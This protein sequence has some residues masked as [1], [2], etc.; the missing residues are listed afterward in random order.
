MAGGASAAVGLI[1]LLGWILGV[2]PLKSTFIG[3]LPM[4]ANTASCFLLTGVGVA[5]LSRPS[6]RA[7]GRWVAFALIGAAASIALV[8]VS[9]YVSGA[10]LGIDQVLF[11][12]APGQ[13][14]TVGP[15]RMS[16]LTS[17]CFTL[18]AFGA[19]ATVRARPAVLPLCGAALALSALNVFTFVFDASVPSFLAA[20]SQMAVNTAI[21]MGVLAV[22][23]IGLLGPASPFALLDR[24]SPTASLLRR[25][26]VAL[27]VVPLSLAWLTQA[28]QRL[29]LYDAGYGTA[30]RLVAVLTLGTI[31]VIRWARWTEEL[32]TR[33]EAVELE[34]DRF[35]EQS[36]DLLAVFGTD[37]RFRRANHAWELTLG[38][39][40][41]ELIGRPYAELVH[42]DDLERTIADSQLRFVDRT[43]VGGFQNRYRHRD[44]RY[45]WL[46]WSSTISPDGSLAYS[47]ARDITD[48][49]RVEERQARRERAL[50]GRNEA[51][52]ERVFRDPLTGLHNRRFFDRAVARI[53]R[54]WRRL[55]VD[56]RPPVAVVIFDLDYFGQI[57]KDHGHQAGDEVLRRFSWLLEQRFRARDLVVRYGGEEFVAVL[58]GV[59]SGM[60]VEIA[61]ALRVAF[62]QTSIGIGTGTPIQVTVSAGC[63][64]LGADGDISA[65]L[66]EADV[67]LSQAKR[68]GRNQVIG[69]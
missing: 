23:V 26:L 11:P 17:A 22:G 61:D 56:R 38:Y 7:R 13:I 37:G 2:D 1:V 27:I 31:G 63:S 35:F 49:K 45:R 47:V 16:P 10:D 62:E 20:Y 48:R 36:V 65:A 9:Q 6:T 57:N 12:E 24:G 5:L 41:G 33:R 58:E 30:L 39:P 3:P 53:Q 54:R 32:E 25:V 21:T 68:G 67:W 18:I 64:Q 40:A 43:R 42:P 15:G 14:A 60:A 52:S 28:G 66:T 50:E 51:L 8:T 55:P 19:V 69:L 59:T 34:R 44:G 46:E 29:G 4:K